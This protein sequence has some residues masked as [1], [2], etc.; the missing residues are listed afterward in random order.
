[1]ATMRPELTEERLQELSSRAEAKFYRACRDQLP[2]DVLVIHSASWTYRDRGG[3][4][5]EG[6]ADF[7]IAFPSAG[8]LAIEVKGG[9]VSFD[10]TSGEW[11][12]IDR[13]GDRNE[14]K[15][16]FKQAKNEKFALLDQLKGHR[17]WRA[18]KGTRMVIGECVMLPDVDN[19]KSLAASGR[20]IEIIGGRSEMGNV[21]A[22]LAGVNA[23]WA[24]AGT[25]PLGEDGVKLVEDILCA[26]VSVRPPLRSVLDEAEQERI[27]LTDA[28]AKILRTIG[29]RKRAVIAGGAGTGKTLIAVE[30]ARQLAADNE[31]ILLLCYNRPLADLLAQSLAGVPKIEVMGFHQLCDRR[32]ALVLER[33]KRDLYEEAKEAYPGNDAK[34]RFEVQMPFALALSSEVL[35]DDLYDSVVVDEAQD[36]SDEYWFS[37]EDLLKDKHYGTLFLF[38]DPNQALYKR[39]A[40]LPVKEDPFY[41]TVNCRNT[42]PVHEKAYAFYKGEP[43]DLPELHGPDVV[44]ETAASVDEQAALIVS[45]CKQLLQGEKVAPSDIAVLLAK[46]PKQALFDRLSRTTLPG[47]VGWSLENRARNAIFVDTVSRFKG[48]EA[49]IVILWI[50]SESLTEESRETLYVGLS[51]AKHLLH[52]VGDETVKSFFTRTEVKA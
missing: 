9:G 23:F 37:I 6:E 25:Q 28:Q 39:H 14:I 1:M 52:V 20:P 2:D 43:V 40:Q 5:R 42:A 46:T 16:P 30:K 4:L 18:W 3:L 48:L 8:I 10:G 47:G 31:R 49:P 17:K 24:A 41:L 27:R 7:T 34:T 33:T 38:S 45:R 32:R 50:G 12:S 13:A 51:R 44:F 36:F 11:F 22:W 29:G 15:D 26:S 19:A 21:A 35:T